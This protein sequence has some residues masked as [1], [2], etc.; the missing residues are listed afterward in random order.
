MKLT[1]RKITKWSGYLLEFSGDPEEAVR[2]SAKVNFK[3]GASQVTVRMTDE[4]RE[5]WREYAR[6]DFEKLIELSHGYEPNE[7]TI[8][9]ELPCG[10]P[11]EGLLA[12]YEEAQRAT[13]FTRGFL[14]AVDELVLSAKRDKHLLQG[15]E[16]SSY[17]L[18]AAQGK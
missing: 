5:E 13:H 11:R 14:P 16:Y 10:Y 7:I 2:P 3:Q 12:I 4:Q 1:E 15:L 18:L 8:S 17:R 9:S 6:R